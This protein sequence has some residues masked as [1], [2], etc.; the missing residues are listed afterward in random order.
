MDSGNSGEVSF[1]WSRPSSPGLG[2]IF[3][4]EQVPRVAVPGDTG[5]DSGCLDGPRLA[6]PAGAASLGQFSRSQSGDRRPAPD[7]VRAHTLR[8]TA[9]TLPVVH[10]AKKDDVWNGVL[11]LSNA[12]ARIDEATGLHEAVEGRFRKAPNNCHRSPQWTDDDR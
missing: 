8:L 10:P 9:S 2:H 3:R 11:F 5:R 4:G 1:R 7:G 12:K 6:P